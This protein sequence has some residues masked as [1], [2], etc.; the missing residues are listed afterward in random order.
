M[1]TGLIEERGKVHAVRTTGDARTLEI[2]GARTIEDVKIDDSIAVNGC[3]LTVV[4]INEK[5]FSAVAVEETLLKTTLGK[6]KAGDSVNLERA[7][8]L[9]DRLGG[10]MV[11][12]HVDGVGKIISIEERSQSWWIGCHIPSELMKYVIPVGS[13]A[14]DGVSLTVAAMTNELIYVSIIPHTWQVTTWSERRPGDAIN[15]EADLIGK[16]IE[17]LTTHGQ[18]VSTITEEWLKEKG[19]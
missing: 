2:L 7:M 12:G 5:S 15:V 19:Y 1:F 17:R 3:C 4:G 14:L 6:L 16:Y 9:N 13:I 8:R 11:L 10:H 18:N